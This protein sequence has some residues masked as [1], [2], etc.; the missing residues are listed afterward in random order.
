MQRAVGSGRVGGSRLGRFDLGGAFL[1]QFDDVVDHPVVRQ[2]VVLF[3]RQVHHACPGPATA[4][5]DGFRLTVKGDGGHGAY[6]HRTVD[7]VTLACR[8]V[9]AVNDL[10]A[11]EVIG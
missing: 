6:P 9:L 1:D 2:F 8:M 5:V 7:P 11:R 4:N 3:A 10:I